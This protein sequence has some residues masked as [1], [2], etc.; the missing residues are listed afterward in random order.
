MIPIL[1]KYWLGAVVAVLFVGAAVLIY[2]KL[3]PPVLAGNLVQGTGRIDGDLINLNTK[4]PGRIAAVAVEEGEAVR[5]N[6]PVAVMMSAEQQAQKTQIEAQI[7]ARKQ[8]LNTRQIELEIARRSL[9]QSVVRAE[10]NL[11]LA[12]HQRH[13]LDQTISA[14]RSLLAQSERDLE[15]VQNLV[16]SRLVESRQLETATLKVRTDKDHLSGLLARGLQLNEM[17]TIARSGRVEAQASQQTI[18]ALEEGI[19]AL[20]SGIKALEASKAQ[21]SAVLAEMELRSPLNGFVVETIAHPGEVVG[22]GA[23]VATLIDPGSFYLKVFVD[24]LENGKI[25]I[26][27]AAVIFLDA[28]PE[29]PIA[30]RVVRIAR[31]AEFTPKEVSVASDRIQRVF[32]V[33]LKPLKPDPMLKLG[34][35]AV[36]VISLDGKGLP[37][38]LREVPE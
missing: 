14:Q 23:P 18:A 26:G 15:R 31:K 8:E 9:P 17:I 20:Q 24:T 3:N 36:G 1:K 28:Q 34:I 21:T 4:Y 25:K 19:A 32:A 37:S 7:E 29:R 30:A 35:P 11:A 13:E 10:A 12:L 38:S 16:E 5:I 33:H 27:D 6:A 2:A 22:A